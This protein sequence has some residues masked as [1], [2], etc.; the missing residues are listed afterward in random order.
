MCS[1]DAKSLS[2]KNRWMVRTKSLGDLILAHAVT[3]ACVSGYVV[4]AGRWEYWP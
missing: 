1:S 2:R 4:L 3:N